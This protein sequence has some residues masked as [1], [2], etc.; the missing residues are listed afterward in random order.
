MRTVRP[1]ILEG[2]VA[3]SDA[4]DVHLPR[5]GTRA[6]S[7]SEWIGVL[8]KSMVETR[9]STTKYGKTWWDYRPNWLGV[10]VS[11]SLQFWGSDLKISQTYD[12][13]V[14]LQWKIY[15]ASQQ[16]SYPT[17]N[18]AFDTSDLSPFCLLTSHVALNM[19]KPNHQPQW[20]SDLVENG[21]LY[22]LN[23]LKAQ[24]HNQSTALSPTS[25][26]LHRCMSGQAWSHWQWLQSPV[27][28]HVR[29]GSTSMGRCWS[30]LSF[31][32]SPWRFFLRTQM[33]GQRG[34]QIYGQTLI[35]GRVLNTFVPVAT[36]R[37]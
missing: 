19:M 16:M 11:I 31:W 7:D 8:G 18:D 35:Y 34:K 27:Q 33:Y 1:E 10:T 28:H 25:R 36:Q 13:G 14:W 24:Q 4:V 5:T 21:K 15:L 20:T 6:N 2:I 9:V 17:S 3:C 22:P 12:Q 23:I 37:E 26:S 30:S 29:C 32:D